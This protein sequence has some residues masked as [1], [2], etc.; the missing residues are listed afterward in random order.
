MAKAFKDQKLVKTIRSFVIQ[1]KLTERI[2][3][4]ELNL[5]LDTLKTLIIEHDDDPEFIDE[6]ELNADQIAELNKF[7]DVKIDP[8]FEENYYVLVCEGVYE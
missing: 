7:L 4:R 2:E 1:N 3:E 8:V 5:S 6:Y